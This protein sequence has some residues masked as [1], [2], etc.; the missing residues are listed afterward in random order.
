MSVCLGSDRNM[1]VLQLLQ[2]TQLCR[3]ILQGLEIW[4][5]NSA[6]TVSFSSPDMF[7]DLHMKNINSCCTV[8]L[9]WKVMLNDILKETQSQRE[10]H[11]D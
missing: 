8:R 1:Q 3:D 9:N 10:R 5:T 2:F 4:D 11:K 7:N 6:G